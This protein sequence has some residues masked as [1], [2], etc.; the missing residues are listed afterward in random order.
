MNLIIKAD[1][2]D[3]LVRKT[4]KAISVDKSVAKTFLLGRGYFPDRS[5]LPLKINTHGFIDINL[6][7]LN[8]S[9]P[10]SIPRT[11]SIDVVVDKDNKGLR[12]FSLIHPFIYIHLVNEILDN[13]DEFKNRLYRETEVRSYNVPLLDG[14]ENT[15]QDWAHFN[16]TDPSQYFLDHAY[17]ATADINNFYE[18]IYTHSISWALHGKEIADIIK[19][20]LSKPKSEDHKQK[21][22]KP[23]PK[24]V[25]RIYDRKV[26][27]LGNFMNWYKNGSIGS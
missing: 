11:S 12:R 9:R 19:S 6:T 16:I 2:P 25:T 8:W 22:K 18:S 15:K 20:K 5:I 4:E 13:Y 26:M 23:K 21:L 24:V 14:D 7:Q 3:Y 17:I 1:S 10:G 27:S